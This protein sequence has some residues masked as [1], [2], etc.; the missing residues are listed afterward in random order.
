VRGAGV[1]HRWIERPI[2]ALHGRSEPLAHQV[3]TTLTAS[4]RIAPASATTHRA[5]PPSCLGSSFT[6]STLAKKA[7]Q[8]TSI[9]RRPTRQHKP[10]VRGS[11]TIWVKYVLLTAS[12]TE[13]PAYR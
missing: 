10:A 7:G 6:P 12:R 5:R 4:A 2:A 13:P 1:R 3:G 9:P 8:R 11:A